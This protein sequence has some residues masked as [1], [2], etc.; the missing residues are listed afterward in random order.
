MATSIDISRARRKAASSSCRFKIAAI[1]IGSRR[2]VYRSNQPR[3]TRSGGSIHAEMA[4]M[5]EHCHGNQIREILLLRVGAG[6]RLLPIHPCA[7]CA[8]KAKELGI[9]IRSLR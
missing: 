1:G 8:A 7:A 5:R 6:G 4:V 2:I 3:Y 9:R